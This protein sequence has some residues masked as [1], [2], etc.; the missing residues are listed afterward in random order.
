MILVSFDIQSACDRVWHT[1]FLYK[2]ASL[3]V[4]L[5]LLHWISAFLSDRVAQFRVGSSLKT[6]L[7]H[8]GVPQGSPSPVAF[9]A[10]LEKTALWIS[11]RVM[12]DTI[13]ERFCSKN[14]STISVI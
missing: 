6:H 3:Y 8:M 7:L 1:G 14:L 4:P 12:A 5:A 13:E 9:K 11:E 2:L 10:P